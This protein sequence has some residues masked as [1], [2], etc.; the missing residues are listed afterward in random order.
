MPTLQLKLTAALTALILF[1]SLLSGVLLERGL[2]ERETKRIERS[3]S[4]RLALVEQLTG[5][6][7]FGAARSAE[8]D[9]IADRAAAAADARV[10]FIT[11]EGLVVGD[12]EV[13]LDRLPMVDNHADR[14]EVRAALRGKIGQDARRSGTI[15]RQLFYLAAPRQ[16]GKGV[17][18]LAVDISNLDDAVWD[19]RRELITA[20]AV[21]LIAAFALSFVLSW[22]TLRPLTEMRRVAAS[23]AGGD[24]E[25]RLPLRVSDELGDI[26]DAINRMAEQLRTQLDETTG[27]KERLDAVLNAMVEGVLVVDAGGELLLANDRLRQI[28]DARG[29]L[30]GRP[31]LEIVRNADFEQLLVDASATDDPVSCDIQVGG[32]ITREL[33]V[34]AVRFPSGDV[35]RVGTVAVFHDMTELRRLEQIRQDFVAN[36]SHELR[37]PL[38]AVQGFTETLLR[39]PQLSEEDKHSYLGIIER[40]ALRLGK[41]VDDLLILSRAESDAANLEFVEVDI[42]SVAQALVN[43]AKRRPDAAEVTLRLV[44]GAPAKAWAERQSVEQ[45]LTNLIDNA[46]KYTEP[47]GRVEVRVEPSEA[48]VEARVSDTGLG[49]PEQDLA[50]IFERFYRVDK[51]R[52]RE[53]GGTGLGLSIVRHLV[54]R[55]GGDIAVDSEL[56]KGSTFSFRL[57]RKPPAGT[58]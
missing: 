14:P 54:Q 17:V 19:L 8:L 44:E 2:R 31:P 3:L 39:A 15:G 4:E 29:P 58:S 35:P 12:S 20:T 11:P 27:E 48:W 30:R 16:Q 13:A 34:Q 40:H 46:I 22:L 9:A 45:V 7:T 49:I 37:T 51:A 36:A 57:P 43:D 55:M 21:G 38:A 23:I 18:R 6:T 33:R 25:T 50:R 47:G 5:T 1:V 32:P 24:L 42:A 10:T 28:F 53:M 52:S 26:S 41:L 56:G